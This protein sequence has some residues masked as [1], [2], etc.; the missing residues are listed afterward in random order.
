MNSKILGK[1]I[2]IFGGGVV[3]C[4]DG[5]Y[6]AKHSIVKYLYELSTF[7]DEIYFFTREHKDGAFLK[8]PVD[9]DLVSIIVLKKFGS[10]FKSLLSDLK[11]V[12][13]LSDKSHVILSM[14]NTWNFLLFPLV[15]RR[16]EL[17]GV[18]TAGD[19]IRQPRRL[20]TSFAMRYVLKRADVV[21]CR[22]HTY[23]VALSYNNNVWESLPIISF[24]EFS[25]GRVP[26]SV[27]S[28]KRGVRLLTVCT[29]SKRK[30]V[31]YILRAL[32]LLIEK[33]VQDYRD[34]RLDIVGDGNEREYLE[35]EANRLN[36]GDYVQFHGYIDEPNKLSEYY[37]EA[38]VFVFHS[39]HEGQPRVLDEAVLHNLPIITADL[40]GIRKHFNH[41]EDALLFEAGSTSQ[42][43]SC[44]EKLV[45][46]R[47]FAL[48]LAENARR[49]YLGRF[50]FE[51]AGIQH[52]TLLARASRR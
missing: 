15:F 52:A 38:D 10:Y 11:S 42:I 36:L 46:E 3:E 37:A 8:T 51:S 45:K 18:Y 47:E 22:G 40:E 44:I 48:S 33:G 27:L 19:W 49:K 32:H 35:D 6:Y 20:G 24:S 14:P 7:F 5:I 16:A 25:E 13:D 34:I 50:H 43:A 4:R 28:D 2:A 30:G 23:D 21:F 31:E 1:R 29:L 17:V 39:F 9:C 26:S 12:Y 41:M